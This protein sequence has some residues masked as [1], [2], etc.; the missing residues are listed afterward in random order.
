MSKEVKK[1]EK[2]G[3]KREEKAR[4]SQQM[5]RIPSLSGKSKEEVVS[6]FLGRQQEDLHK[7]EETHSRIL[8]IQRMK[9]LEREKELQELKHCTFSPNISSENK[10]KHSKYK[11][12]KKQL[13][14]FEQY[15]D[16]SD[17]SKLAELT[18]C[19]PGKHPSTPSANPRMLK[20]KI[21][22]SSSSTFES[23]L[24]LFHTPTR[25]FKDG[26]ETP[27][28]S[29]RRPFTP[30]EVPSSTYSKS[31]SPRP[32]V[33]RLVESTK[34]NGFKNR[35]SSRNVTQVKD[36]CE[37]GDGANPPEPMSPHQIKQLTLGASLLVKSPPGLRMP[38]LSNVH[39][40]LDLDELKRKWVKN[41]KQDNK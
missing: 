32:S 22:T 17:K 26:A 27:S 39:K 23:Y 19:N 15:Q 4:E 16:E 37:V 2:I 36:D 29:K 30:R 11:I 38:S 7:R 18:A 9:K 35:K 5:L 33:K 28:Y 12:Q 40:A 13:K 8:E 41:I 34:K 10:S 21:E 6:H 24:G 1:Q 20:Q 14:R 25:Q 3:A 31:R